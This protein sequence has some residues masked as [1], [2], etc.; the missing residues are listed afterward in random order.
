MTRDGWTIPLVYALL[1]NKKTESYKYVLEKISERRG[2]PLSPDV[3][4]MDF[5]QSEMRAVADVFPTA[6]LQGCHFHYTQSLYRHFTPHMKR[7]YENDNSFALQMKKIFALAFVL[8]CDVNRAFVEIKS[9]SAFDEDLNKDLGV[10]FAYVHSTYIGSAY[11]SSLYKREFWSV[12]D[13][14]KNNV[15]RTNNSLE[16]WNRRFGVLCESSH[17]PLYRIIKHL[18]SEQHSTVVM[19]ASRIS[20]KAPAAKRYKQIQ[21][22]RRLLNLVDNYATLELKDF[23]KGVA[24]NMLSGLGT[25]RRGDK[26]NNDAV[27][28]S[29]VEEEL[30]QVIPCSS[31]FDPTYTHV[32]CLKRKR[33]NAGTFSKRQKT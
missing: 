25:V 26:S 3:V 19:L 28:N 32:P 8:P 10:F 6:I 29:S 15:A 33:T 18:Q 16:A 4:L 23:V 12:H 14:V 20:G 1:P 9:E 31:S 2:L 7:A 21:L 11:V 22:N 27:D 24:F 5:E 30:T 13:R 17:I